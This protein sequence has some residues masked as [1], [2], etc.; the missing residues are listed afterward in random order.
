[1]IAGCFGSGIFGVYA[2]G[3]EPTC[4]SEGVGGNLA[5]MN[6]GVHLAFVFPTLFRER[7]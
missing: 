5:F 3:V 4:T 7:L 2:W 1:M 6:G